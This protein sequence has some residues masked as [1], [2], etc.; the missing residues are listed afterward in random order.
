M[1]TTIQARAVG[2]AGPVW[3][4]AREG[5]AVFDV[6]LEVTVDGP[7][8]QVEDL[9]VHCPPDMRVLAATPLRLRKGRQALAMRMVAPLAA[10]PRSTAIRLHADAPRSQGAVVVVQPEPWLFDVPGPVAPRMALASGNAVPN[11]FSLRAA[12]NAVPPF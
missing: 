6:C 2:L 7:I 8:A 5:L 12:D 4:D 3:L 9:A 10:S 1:E 11:A